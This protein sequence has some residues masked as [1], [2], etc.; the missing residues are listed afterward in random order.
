MP[1]RLLQALIAAKNDAADDCLLEA[2]RF[3]SEPEKRTCL[4]A[5]I[6]RGTERGLGGVIA[7]YDKLPESLQGTVLGEIRKFHHA[8]R[9][10]GRSDDPGT[11]LAAL[12]LIALG[13]QGKLAY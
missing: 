10:C 2:M 5:L 3:G 1:D 6:R 8:I 11:R 4:D 12:K 9:E 7:Q 13:R